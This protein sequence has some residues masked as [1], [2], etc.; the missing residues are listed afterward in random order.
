[1]LTSAGRTRP[2]PST[3][4]RLRPV[5]AAGRRSRPAARPRFPALAPEAFVPVL[6]FAGPLALHQCPPAN[7]ARFSPRREPPISASVK[8]DPE[9]SLLPAWRIQ[10]LRRCW[11][12]RRLLQR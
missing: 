10:G 5:V 4:E 6:G 8:Q 7:W 2:L 3:V 11:T 1:M 12:R 9:L